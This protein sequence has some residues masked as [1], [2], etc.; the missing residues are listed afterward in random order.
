MQGSDLP[1]P[2]RRP[3]PWP[4]PRPVESGPRLGGGASLAPPEPPT[5]GALLS[6]LAGA[7][8]FRD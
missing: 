8:A 6:G 1:K 5:G 4:A 3:V 2:G 7:A